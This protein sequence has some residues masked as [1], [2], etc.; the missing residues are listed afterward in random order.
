MKY[1][2]LI[3]LA[4]AAVLLPETAL[5]QQGGISAVTVTANDDGSQTYSVTLQILAVMTAL[6]FIPALVIMTTSFTRIIIV[7]AILRQAIGLQ[8]SPS[9][10]IL[11]GLTLFLTFF[12]MSP[13]FNQINEEA[14]QPYLAEE[15]MPLEA[16][17]RDRKSTRL[18]SSHVRISYAVFCLKKKKKKTNTSTTN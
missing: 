6:S 2:V 18:N 12:I 17:E 3:C 1:L 16:V 14:L 11:L 8:S 9:N 13:I 10:Q 5:A 4:F 15:I 7:L